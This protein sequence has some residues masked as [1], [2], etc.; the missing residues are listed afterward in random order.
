VEIARVVPVIEAHRRDARCRH[1]HRH[2]SKPEVMAAAVAAGACIVN[3][4]RALQRP[5]AR[6]A[7]RGRGR[8][9]A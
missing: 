6:S 7:P 1:F 4:V 8:A 5:G 9:C 2:F 3:D